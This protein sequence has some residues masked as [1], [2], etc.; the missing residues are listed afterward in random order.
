MEEEKNE[1]VDVKP[2]V[3]PVSRFGCKTCTECSIHRPSECKT[4]AKL[5]SK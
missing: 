2:E 4:R 1:F 5:Q 3:A